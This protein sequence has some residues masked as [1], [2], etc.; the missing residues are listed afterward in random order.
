M[1]LLPSPDKTPRV[2]LGIDIRFVPQFYWARPNW[3]PPGNQFCSIADGL[4]SRFQR[5]NF[6]M[7][8][9]LVGLFKKGHSMIHKNVVV[10]F[11]SSND[12]TDLIAD[13]NVR[14]SEMILDMKGYDPYL[15]RGELR[16]NHFV[17]HNEHKDA[18]SAVSAKWTSLG[19]VFVGQWVEDSLEYLFR[20]QL[21]KAPTA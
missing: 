8:Q 4:Q 13:I 17:G 1:P 21:Q 7:S 18:K 12:D 16:E 5:D 3:L 14:D 15:I 10:K 9:L 11:L 19:D 2:A 6:P 20:F